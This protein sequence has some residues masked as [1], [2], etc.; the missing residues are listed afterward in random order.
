M[1]KYLI[2]ILIIITSSCK[3]DMVTIDKVISGLTIS[4]RT[5]YADGTT[6]IYMSAQLNSNTDADKR[7]VIF[8]ASA[9]SFVKAN[10]TLITQPATFVNGSLIAT[11]AFKVPV[12]A[13][14][15]HL[16]VRP[17]TASQYA[18]YIIKD[19]IS[20]IPSYPATLMLVPSVFA[21]KA[22]IGNEILLT[23]TLRNSSNNYVS[24]GT[25]V[26]FQDY[27]P[28]GQPANGRYR[29]LRDTTDATSTA[30]AY[31]SLGNLSPGTTFY[32]KCTYLAQFGVITAIKDSCLIT[33]NN[34]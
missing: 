1:K 9:G 32:I 6:I 13:G 21:V 15:I 8:E 30:T 24:S 12:T 26:L 19:T 10:D 23:A 14:K 27:L 20:A 7:N 31:Y 25:K 11:V 4:N 33:V 3:P 18:D 5:P 28:N 34:P 17:A 2:L 29:A 16:S 22:D